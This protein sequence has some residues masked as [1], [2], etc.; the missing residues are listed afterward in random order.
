LRKKAPNSKNRSNMDKISPE[1]K[2][3]RK[4]FGLPNHD[5]ITY[6]QIHGTYKVLY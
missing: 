1:E 2:A 6:E 3:D 4:K 5:E